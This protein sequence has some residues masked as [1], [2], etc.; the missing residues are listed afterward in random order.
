MNRSFQRIAGALGG[1]SG[2]GPWRSKSVLAAVVAVVVGMGFWFSDIKGS[3]PQ[4][5]TNSVPTNAPAIT[6]ANQAGASPASSHWNWSKPFP[7]YVRLGASYT[8]GF[9]LGWFF[10]KLIRL[11]LVVAALIIVLLALGRFAGCD[12]THTQTE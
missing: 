3:P 7:F 8:A 12:T 6:P 2:D 9:C 11:I 10:R 5:E 1:W 4:Y